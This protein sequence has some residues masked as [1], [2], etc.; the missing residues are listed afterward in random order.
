MIKQVTA[1]V[2]GGRSA[3]YPMRA[4]MTVSQV[5]GRSKVKSENSFL[6]VNDIQPYSEADSGPLSSS[7]ASGLPAASS[8]SF[9]I[10]R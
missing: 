3:C 1:A 10:L 8:C 2:R 5:N 4:P 6:I 9:L 7:L